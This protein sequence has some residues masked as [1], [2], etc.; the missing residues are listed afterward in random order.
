MRKHAPDRAWIGIR[1][2]SFLAPFNTRCRIEAT[3]SER[4]LTRAYPSINP[5]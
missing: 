1:T 4:L 3:H 2:P 5:I